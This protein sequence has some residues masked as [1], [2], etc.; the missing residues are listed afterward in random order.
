[1]LSVDPCNQLAFARLGKIYE[2]YQ[3][4]YENALLIY[5][6]GLEYAHSYE[7]FVKIGDCHFKLG[8]LMEAYLNY[9]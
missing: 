4:D 8:S 9:K 2:A 3:N 1:M 6:K 7:N 5:K